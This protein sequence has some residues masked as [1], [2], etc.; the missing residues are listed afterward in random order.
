MR[1]VLVSTS[2]DRRFQLERGA[3]LVV[4]RELA[5]EIPILD[6]GVSRRQS[7]V[8]ADAQGI[9]ITDLDSR[10]GTWINGVRITQARARLGDVIAFGTVAFTLLEVA[11]AER[12]PTL[13]GSALD[14][15]S[16]V[17]LERAVPSRETALAEVAGQRLSKLVTLAQRLGGL[18]SVEQLLPIIVDDLLGAFDAD[19]VA[20]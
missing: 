7:E 3:T 16:T 13:V 10:N 5:C 9:S 18:T 20:V 1:F 15:A 12:R 11:E 6:A 14:G 8:R 4:G 2:G 19:R 17:V